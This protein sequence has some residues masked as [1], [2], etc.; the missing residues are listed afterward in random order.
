[1]SLVLKCHERNGLLVQMM[2]TMQQHGCGDSTLAQQV[3]QLLGDAA[4]K[5][6]TA[7][8]TSSS[9]KTWDYSSGFAPGFISKFMDYANGSAP[10]LKCSITLPSLNMQYQNESEGNWYFKCGKC[11]SVSEATA[12]LQAYS[13]EDTSA[14][15]RAVTKN[16]N[17]AVPVLPEQ[18][19]TRVPV[20][21]S[22]T[23]SM[24]E[25][26]SINAAKVR[27]CLVVISN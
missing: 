2:K 27:K 17:L 18:V 9:V 14:S 16:A 24:E 22:P 1:M 11:F 13:S 7:A 4:L 15:T 20:S 10:D 26:L 3:E 23:V 6:Y 8:F 12:N 25:S 21:L 19:Q 5:D